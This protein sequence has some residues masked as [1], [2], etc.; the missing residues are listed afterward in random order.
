MLNCS[1]TNVSTN[2]C[3]CGFYPDRNKCDCTE[4]EVRKYL[5]KISGPILDRMDLCVYMNPV[6]YWEL[7][8]ERQQESSEEIRVRVNIAAAIQR[9]RYANEKIHYNSQLQ[10]V[11]IEKYCKLQKEEEGIVKDIFEKME[12]SVRAYEKL[13]K[14]SRTIADL[15]EKE[16]ISIEELAEAVSYK[17]IGK[18]GNV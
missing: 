9:K 3:R 15:K 8:D 6:S 10:G 16:K 4:R 2:P 5:Q 18:G 11:M 13:L 7:K 12:L 1:E 17:M 14:V